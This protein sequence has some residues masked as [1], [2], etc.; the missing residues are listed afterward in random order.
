[1]SASGREG[2]GEDSASAALRR[3]VSSLC[4]GYRRLRDAGAPSA[5]DEGAMGERLQSLVLAEAALRYGATSGVNRRR[6]AQVAVLGPTQTGKST[7]VNLL[8]GSPL[9]EVSPLAGF[10]VHPRGFWIRATASDDGWTSSLFPGWHRSEPPDLRRDDLEAYGLCPV[11]PPPALV[12]CV[13]WDTPDFDSLAAR[14]YARGVLEVAA[15]ADLYL[16]VLSKEKY[17]DLSVWRFLELIA[18]LGRPL[19]I[20][21][22]KVTADAEE[23]LLGSLHERLVQRGQ[24]WGAVPIVTLPYDAGLAAGESSRASALAPR[25]RDA[26]RERL[27]RATRRET[28][29]AG[30]RALLRRHWDAWL[31]PVRAEHEAHAE[32]QRMVLT[33]GAEFLTA[34]TRDYLEHPQRYDSFRR[35]AVELLSLLEL[36]RIGGIVTWARQL[37]TW[38]ARQVIA[39]GRG[40]WTERHRP[41]GTAHTLQVESAVLLDTLDGLLAGLQRDVGRRCRPTTAGYPFWAA[42]ERKLEAELPRVRQVCEQAIAAHHERVT[43]EVHEAANRLFAELQKSPARLTA[44]RTARAVLDAGSILLAVKTGGLSLLDAVWAPAT[45]AVSSLLM[46]GIAGLEMGHAARDLKVRQRAAVE[47][48]LVG[49]TL[50]P[51]LGSVADGLEGAGLF[52]IT[53]DALQAASA[54]LVAWEARS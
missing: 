21:L 42:L 45:F 41:R 44:L 15:L 20:A 4:A 14:Q 8:L 5:A 3:F 28:R 1:V 27:E 30:A 49:R 52:G 19:V 9:A 36:P 39:A 31:A 40:W 7:I 2:E 48:V 53:A 16:L 37:V 25:L 50:L 17:S 22:N 13:I 46:E 35:A 10:T 34:Y 47:S 18:P 54:A 6:P 43:R 33:A 51:Q 29:V 26:V 24:A 32:W 38:P 12:P 11:P 23:T